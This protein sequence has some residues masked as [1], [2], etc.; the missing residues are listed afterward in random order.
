MWERVVRID[1]KIPQTSNEGYSGRIL[2]SFLVHAALEGISRGLGSNLIWDEGLKNSRRRDTGEG[3][4][5]FLVG[6]RGKE[7]LLLWLLCDCNYVCGE[8]L[9]N[10]AVTPRANKRR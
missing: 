8:S 6:K 4:T 3:P 1:H 10:Q 9:G 7:T 5:L 2:V